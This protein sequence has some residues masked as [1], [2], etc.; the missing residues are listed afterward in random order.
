MNTPEST[1]F[2]A[3]PVVS[4]LNRVAGFDPLRFLKKTAN[5]HELD[6]RYKKLWFRLKYPAGRTRLT[7]L[8]ITD[9]LAIIEAKVF[10][11]KDDADP[12][13]SYIATMTQEN[14]PAGLYEQDEA[15]RKAEWEARQR[16]KEEAEQAAWKNAV[17]M[18]D[19]EL[20]AA[21]MKRVGDDSERLTRRNM[22]QCVTEY[23]QTLCLE[24]VAFARN[25]MH[26]RKN[27]VN[28]FRYINRRAFEFAKQEMEDNDVKPSA[29]GYGTD[30][31]DGLCYQWT[32]G[33]FKDM[34]AKEDRGQEEKFVPKP[35]YGGKN[36]RFLICVLPTKKGVR[37]NCRKRRRRK[38]RR[39]PPP[40]RRKNQPTRQ[41]KLHPWTN[42]S[43]S[44]A[45][46]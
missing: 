43:L 10:F 1:L 35:Y 20:M 21:S 13:S 18:S 44:I 4:E 25:V 41:R 5:G 2:N 28:C 15:K 40:K 27:M 33:Y 45:W 16:A 46:G 37:W 24:D 19:D 17:A 31:P 42:R 22:K 11:D 39:S 8:R 14:A 32:E 36:V 7:P 23:I 6:L 29:E 9:Q 34:N 38:K 26:P 12:A 30:V 3:V